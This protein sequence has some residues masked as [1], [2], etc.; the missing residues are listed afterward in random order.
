MFRQILLQICQIKNISP[1]FV[2]NTNLIQ[3]LYFVCSQFQQFMYYLDLGLLN[4]SEYSSGCRIMNL[5]GQP[6]FQIWKNLGLHLSKLAQNRP[7]FRPAR[8]K[9]LYKA[10]DR[11]FQIEVCVCCV[12]QCVVCCVVLC[13]VCCVLCVVCCVLCVVLCVVCFFF[14]V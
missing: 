3:I 8:T 10:K 9:L 1:K 2:V 14:C 4:I 13:V 12:V 11:F 5:G 6:S 7:M